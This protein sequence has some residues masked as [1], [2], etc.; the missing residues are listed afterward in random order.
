MYIKYWRSLRY[1]RIAVD[2]VYWWYGFQPTGSECTF[3]VPGT[4]DPRDD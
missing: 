3:M 2:K 4:V 1:W